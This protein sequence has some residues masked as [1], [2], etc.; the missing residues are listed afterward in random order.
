MTKALIFAIIR[1]L[2]IFHLFY[3]VLFEV[4]YRYEMHYRYLY[5]KYT[6]SVSLFENLSQNIMLQMGLVW[7]LLARVLDIS[8]KIGSLQFFHR[9]CPISILNHDI[10]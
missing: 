5:R 2:E 9:M 8:S 1:K 10:D 4:R 6:E 7:L 3:V